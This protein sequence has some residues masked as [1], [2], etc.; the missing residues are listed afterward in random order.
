MSTLGP[1][2]GRMP[3]YRYYEDGTFEQVVHDWEHV[4]RLPSRGTYLA[5]WNDFDQRWEFAISTGTRTDRV[6][7]S[8]HLPAPF[9]AGLLLAGV[10]T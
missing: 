2:I 5:V 7:D 8:T 1:P 6:W 9:R 4:V 3:Q 10:Q